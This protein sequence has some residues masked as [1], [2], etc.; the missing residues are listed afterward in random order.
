ALG[1]Q[2]ADGT[3]SVQLLRWIPTQASAGVGQISGAR[4]SVYVDLTPAPSISPPP[5]LG[6]AAYSRCP[7]S[8]RPS[9]KEIAMTDR[10]AIVTTPVSFSVLRV[11]EDVR[12]AYERPAPAA[13]P[14]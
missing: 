13:R 9:V 4:L 12:D 6:G 7:G 14:A 2:Q 5:A 10:F 3:T 11:W 1:H 8:T